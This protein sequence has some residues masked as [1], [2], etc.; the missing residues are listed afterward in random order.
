MLESVYSNLSMISDILCEEQ[1]VKVAHSI[2]E[3]LSK[4]I[5]K[6]NKQPSVPLVRSLLYAII[7]YFYLCLISSDTNFFIYIYDFLLILI[8]MFKNNREG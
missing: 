6:Y 3:L 8:I 7:S 1:D 5:L 2:A 4:S